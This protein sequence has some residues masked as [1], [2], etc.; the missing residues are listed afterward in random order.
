MKASHIPEKFIHAVIKSNV[1]QYHS[2][3]E[4]KRCPVWSVLRSKQKVT[5]IPDAP[6]AGVVLPK[7]PPPL[8]APNVGVDPNRPPD[9][10]KTDLRG[11]G[12]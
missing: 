3:K 11:K 12:S 7:S 1:Q 9:P 8:L 5:D 2:A 4:N 10:P 6:N